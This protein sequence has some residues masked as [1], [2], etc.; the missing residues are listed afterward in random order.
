MGEEGNMSTTAVAPM[1]PTRVQPHHLLSAILTLAKEQSH[2]SRFAFRGHDYQLQNVFGSLVKSESYPLLKAF[3]FSNNGPE[4][5]SPV[6]NESVAKLQLA[7][8]IGRENPD[9]EVVFLRP[10]ADKFFNEDLKKR[11]GPNDVAELAKVAADFLNR[12]QVLVTEE[13]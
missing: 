9:Y 7:G 10:A 2:A 8:L 3:V 1:T 6:L 5:Y 11:L 12:V 13:A 4:P